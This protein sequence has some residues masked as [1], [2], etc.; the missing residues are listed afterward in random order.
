MH[1]HAQQIDLYIIIVCL[2]CHCLHPILYKMLYHAQQIDLYIIVVI[3]YI[4]FCIKCITMHICSLL[5][6]MFVHMTYIL[7]F[8]C[9]ILS[10][11]TCF[12]HDLLIFLHFLR[13]DV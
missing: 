12:I 2:C 6:N 5:M 1:Y 7:F 10:C 8:N 11:F 4:L 3:V 9:N 13:W